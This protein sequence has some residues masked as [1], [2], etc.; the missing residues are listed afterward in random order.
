MRLSNERRR[1]EAFQSNWDELVQRYGDR[2]KVQVRRFLLREGLCPEPEE[3]EDRVQEVYCR[4]LHGG[5]PL[6]R[7]LR[8]WSEAQVVSYLWRTAQRVIFDGRRAARA[9]KRGGRAR[10]VLGGLLPDL[11]DRSAGHV[12]PRTP[13][14]LAM[15]AQARRIVLDR[16]RT[17]SAG[18]LSPEDRERNLRIL[19]LAL[20]DGW[21]SR[22]I[23]L[24][25]GG[26]LAASTVDTLV[27]R[28]RRRLAPRSELPIR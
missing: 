24:A 2:V 20:L 13:E 10:V 22:E 3:V 6:L 28:A 11:A 1:E 18:A 14:D 5:A 17:F 7:R 15:L 16:C 27:H 19:S 25:E 4:L 26:R 8:S 12:D 21:S 9:A 23:A